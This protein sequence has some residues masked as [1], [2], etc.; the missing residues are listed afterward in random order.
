MKSENSRSY[1]TA[2]EEIKKKY[3]VCMFRDS[4]DSSDKVCGTYNN[5]FMLMRDVK[6][7]YSYGLYDGLYV[8]F[9]DDYK[10]ADW[11]VKVL[12]DLNKKFI[13]DKENA[14]KF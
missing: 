10:S 11:E 3:L 13:E 5:Y 6:E 1:A 4:K 2:L 9:P 14:T 8:A 7:N 12:E